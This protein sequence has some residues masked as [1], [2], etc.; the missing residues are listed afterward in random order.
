MSNKVGVEFCA[1]TRGEYAKVYPGTMTGQPYYT[2]SE[3]FFPES[4]ESLTFNGSS[5][6][7]T[8]ANAT[9]PENTTKIT[10]GLDAINNIYPAGCIPVA[11]G[12][13]Y[14][15]NSLNCNFPCK[16]TWSHLTVASQKLTAWY[17][18]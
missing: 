2:G 17:L 11:R 15:Q 9:R 12:G 10:D 14:L 1:V 18:A 4:T 16:Y 3:L 13:K 7:T 5:Y 8:C 6:T